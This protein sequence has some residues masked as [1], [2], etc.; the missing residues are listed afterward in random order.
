MDEPT[1]ITVEP[2][3][4]SRQDA[5]GVS[6]AVSHG[7]REAEVVDVTVIMPTVF[8][9]GTFE[10]CARRVLRVLNDSAAN[11]EVIFAFDGPPTPVPAWVDR[12]G[13][14]CVSTG[15]RSGPAIA[16]NAAAEVARG[17]VLFF[18]DA[19]VELAADA[20]DRVA[21][22]F[23]ADPDMVCM[24]GAY[25]DEPAA[26]GLVSS[27]RNLLHHH[28]HVA[29]RGRADTFW[30]GCGAIRR[31]AFLDAGGFDAAWRHP[32]M[33]DV[34]LGMRI[35]AQGGRIV[36]D[37]RLRCKSLKR[38]T[39]MSMVF[40]D[41]AHRAQPWT[42]LIVSSRRLPATLNIDWPS[43]LS[44]ACAML[45][46]ACL[47]A[48][49]FLPHAAWMAGGLLLSLAVMNREFYL[50]CMRKGGLSC[51]VA[52]FALH[53]LY[54]I[55]SS[56]TFGWVVLEHLWLGACRSAAGRSRP[57]GRARLA[58]HAAAA[59]GVLSQIGR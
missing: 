56:I 17:R 53:T 39:L 26:T 55:Y 27:F 30:T 16:R 14:R 23:S 32:M 5:T 46:V 1:A 33:E 28:T 49:S 35:A 38:W 57:A 47:V 51:A 58:G 36:L 19:D 9:T 8:W 13:V 48:T 4:L 15:R 3:R 50:L 40:E 18:V 22:A 59:A 12:P 43:R 21:E 24:L 42:H 31:S 25:D 44:G 34:E 10:R 6:S 37:P 29:H 20:I 7:W 45:L 2:S 11:A 54:F 52:S 41:I